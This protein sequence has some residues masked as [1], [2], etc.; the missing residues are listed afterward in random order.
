MITTLFHPHLIIL[1][2]AIVQQFIFLSSRL[3]IL[4]LSK[5]IFLVASYWKYDNINI[6][7]VCNNGLS[8]FLIRR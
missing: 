3:C 8:F 5:I 1:I 6:L 7:S 4:N 2:Q